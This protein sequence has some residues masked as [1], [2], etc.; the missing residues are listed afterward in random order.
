MPTP[1]PN[2]TDGKIPSFDITLDGSPMDSTI[3]VL[4]INVWKSVNKVSRAVITILAG[5]TYMGTFQESELASFVPGTEVTIKMGYDQTNTGVFTGVLI[6]HALSVKRG[7]ENAY[8]RSLLVLECADKAIKMTLD[9]KSEIFESKM[10]S[11]I[12]T[13]ILSQYGLTKTVVATTYQHAFMAQYNVSDW[14][15]MIKRAHANGLVVLNSDNAVDIKKPTAT[16]S[17]IAEV[18]YGESAYSFEAEIDASTQLKASSA[19]SWDTF[20]ESLVS[21]TGSEPSG[22]TSP[23]NL[24]GATL[25]AVVSPA[26]W[27]LYYSGPLETDELKAIADAAMAESRLKRVRGQVAFRGMNTVA[28]GTIIT[29]SGFGARFD[30]DVYVTGIE[31]EMS[32]GNFTTKVVFGLPKQMFGEASFTAESPLL[33]PIRGMHV[34]IVKKIDGDPDAGYRIQVQ[35]PAL[36]ESGNGLWARL[37]Q[38][39]ATKDAGSFFIPEV[40]SEVVVGFLN[41]DPRF[42]VVLGCLYDT[43]NKPYTT[44]T[45]A[46]SMKAIVTTNKLTLEFDD[47]KKVITLKTPG[48]NS[49][50]ISDDAAGITIEDQN[51]NSVKTSSAGITINSSKAINIKSSQ[52]VTISGGTGVDISA[53][54]GDVGIKGLNVNAQ[55]DIKFSGK[56][57]A[58]AE[59]TASGQVVVKGAIVMIN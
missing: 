27:N 41:D 55:A 58:Q 20:K 3:V 29:L 1:S 47:D 4:G 51:G 17:S 13:T 52:K 32:D 39:F 25:S 5:D 44:F 54:G 9:N 2:D 26:T 6:K 56:G 40:N 7:Y 42:P 49:I 31:H 38:F 43:N 16:T 15:F 14:D 23:G 22:M 28:L 10:D 30:G 34:G 48:G 19:K 35:I 50:V 11:D 45:A 37:T 8:N 57:T 36:K 12:I 46:N 18:V 53:S 24:T 33:S 59:L 21:Q